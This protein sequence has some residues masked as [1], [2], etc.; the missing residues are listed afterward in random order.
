VSEIK[1]ALEEFGRLKWELLE[2]DTEWGP[3][4][5]A[6]QALADEL[7]EAQERLTSLM[8]A[9]SL[10]LVENGNFSITLVRQDRGYYDPERLPSSV[11]AIPG[12][13]TEVVDKERLERAIKL[14][15][16]NAE[17]LAALPDAWV[18]KPIK[19]SIRVSVVKG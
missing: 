10:S 19:P 4:L 3:M 13:L 14:S 6:R 9:A 12:I 17:E 8:A 15:M 18:S 11:R 7:K 16:L 5:Q 1:T 2:F